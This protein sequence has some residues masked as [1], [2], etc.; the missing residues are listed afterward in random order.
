VNVALSG[1]VG[2]PNTKS[3][4][5]EPP[6]D[7]RVLPLYHLFQSVGGATP[8]K[9]NEDYWKGNIPWV[10]PKDMKTAVIDD[11]IDH[12]SQSALN[13]S[14][15]ALLPTGSVLIVVRGMIL[16]HT[17]PVATTSRPVTINQD[18][19]GLFPKNGV[20]AEFLAFLLRAISP[21]LFSTIEES[22]HGTRCLR[23][24]LWRNVLVGVPSKT[25]QERILSFI[26]R[27]TVQIDAVVGKKQRLIERL[28][29]KRQALISHAVTKGLNPHAPM[30]DSGFE[31]LKEV[32][33]HWMVRC[34][35]HCGTIPNGQA[36]PR[37][38]EYRDMVLIAPN[39]IESETGRLIQTETAHDQRAESGKYVAQKGDV[40]YSKIRP[41][42]QKA[43]IAPERCLCSAD[44]YPIT[45]QRDMVAEYILYNLLCDWFTKYAVLWS[46][47]VAMPKVN[48]ETLGNC[49]MV[50]PPMDEQHEIV[51]YIKTQT[52]HIDRMAD[53]IRRQVTKLQEY[54]Q[55]LIS[56]AVT[57]KIDVTKERD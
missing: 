29:E 11:S 47:R 18:M 2:S 1:T 5:F 37:L 44:M 40:I 36:D 30:K 54:R 33:A 22:G 39:H 52:E 25:H 6:A 42:L 46:D 57:G 50:V 16:V 51:R 35:R 9:D 41:E 13:E 15:L 49:L 21:L 3:L 53:R 7:W 48:R 31:W 24:D 34:F 19:K 17:I 4:A 14:R 27:K 38:A 8:S 55:T 56:A 28:Q 12:I 26:R 45:P 43:C 10:S 20:N 23:L 32:P